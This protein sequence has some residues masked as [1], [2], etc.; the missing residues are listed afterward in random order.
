MAEVRTESTK[1]GCFHK[2]RLVSDA[3]VSAASSATSNPSSVKCERPVPS[4]PSENAAAQ[5]VF[6]IGADFINGVSCFSPIFSYIPAM[7]ESSRALRAATL[8]LLDTRSR[9]SSVT[10][11][12]RISDP[13]LYGKAL[14]ALWQAL[15]NPAEQCELPTFLAAV[16][17]T[18]LEVRAHFEP[19]L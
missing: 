19:I 7:L 1:H 16:V 18:R 15:M 12:V 2:L 17:L 13:V 5:L 8:S 4:S 3:E 9:L 11:H 10:D 6:A 14:R